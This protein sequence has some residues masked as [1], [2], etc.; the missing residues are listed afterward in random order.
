MAKM[1]YDVVETIPR[2][3]RML[4]ALRSVGYDFNAAV[5]DIVDNSISAGAKEINVDFRRTPKGFTLIIRDD[6]RGMSKP[7][8]REAMRH[9][10]DVEYDPESL[11]K[12]GMG[13][14]TASLSQCRKL[15]VAS[16]SGTTASGL[17]AF[18]WDLAHIDKVN[19]WELL[20]I[21]KESALRDP[22]FKKILRSSGTVVSWEEMDRFDADLNSYQ[23]GGNADNWVGELIGELQTYLRMTFHRF[24][25][26][27]LGSRRNLKIIYNG[28]KLTPW[29]PFCRC[30]K[31][32]LVLKPSEFRPVE[33]K[34]KSAVRIEPFVLPEKDGS[35]GFSTLPAWNEAKG[36]LPW[37]DSQGFYIYR[38]NRLIHYGGWLRI[39]GKSEHTKYARVGVYFDSSLDEIFQISVHK[40]KLNLPASLFDHLKSATQEAVKIAKTRSEKR[41][42]TDGG[43]HKHGIAIVADAIPEAFARHSVKVT[44]KRDG[45]VIVTNR[46]GSFT[47]DSAEGSKP[48]RLDHNVGIT[49]GVVEDGRFW[50]VQCKPDG[51]FLVVL[52]AKHPFYRL[53]YDGAKPDRTKFLD[54]V[55]AAIGF[56]E[57]RSGTEKN[58][59]LFSEI[60]DT[61][62]TMLSDMAKS[63]TLKN[64][65]PRGRRRA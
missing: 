62:S 46:R 14:K 12:F 25:D 45:S 7:V 56:T 18:M 16:N 13:L 20:D 26:G 52:N 9:G 48:V 49:A 4:R 24:M 37:N 1:K 41:R 19:R 55:F 65:L 31:N 3:I 28:R 47:V 38:E 59:A 17:S 5:G 36:L 61:I 63:E 64:G 29:D 58:K 60:R 40:M 6:G 34:S 42:P 21:A 8:L 54:S 35:Q 11:G 22:R 50:K 30:E 32:T 23:R 2:A 33:S 15:L 44:T 43:I 10:S 53:A 27:S 51:G 39:R 57:L